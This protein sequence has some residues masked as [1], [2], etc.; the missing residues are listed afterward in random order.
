MKKLKIIFR[1]LIICFVFASLVLFTPGR[2][3]EEYIACFDTKQLAYRSFRKISYFPRIL[4]ATALIKHYPKGL[5]KL[6]ARC[7]YYNLL[8]CFLYEKRIDAE[9]KITFIEGASAKEIEDLINN[10]N[11]FSSAKICVQEGELFPETYCFNAGCNRNTIITMAKNFM[12]KK[13]DA[14][15]N[16]LETHAKTANIALPINKAEFVI[17]ASI[18]QKE[19]ANVEDLQ[20]I[21][22]CFLLRLQK[23]I[24]LHSCATALYGLKKEG[25]E[26]HMKNDIPVLWLSD[27]KIKT[28][29]NTYLL[30]RFPIGPICMPGAAALQAVADVLHKAMDNAIMSKKGK[31]LKYDAP[32]YFYS[33][34]GKII[35]ANTLDDHNIN[36]FRE[37]KQLR[38]K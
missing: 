15:W 27:T 16:E 2:N 12:Q 18:V 32:L 29:Y 38:K 19:G 13:V 20:K 1:A 3:K 35:Y 11:N 25:Y 28:K 7:S 4:A 34:D 21:A 14:L 33:K 22:G 9:C 5:W 31:Q 17:L 26:I 37:K 8:Y 23:R 6:P 36:K 10:D 24:R 30:D